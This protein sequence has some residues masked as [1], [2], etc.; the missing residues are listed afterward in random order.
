MPRP[1]HIVVV[2]EENRSYSDVIG[3]PDAPYING[4]AAHGAVFPRSFAVAHPSQPNYLA[5]F[6]GST[7]GV[8]SDSCPQTFTAVSLGQ[9][10]AV[11]GDSLGGY[12]EDLPA[13]GF[14]GCTHGGYARK[15]NPWSDFPAVPAAVNRALGAFPADYATLPTVSFVIPDLDHDM[16]DGSVAEGDAWLRERLNG[17]AQWAGTHNSLLILTWDEDDG[18]AGNQIPTIILGA[19]VQPGRY[20]ERVTHYRV[21]RTIEEA[22][23]LPPL[24]DAAHTAPISDI[25]AR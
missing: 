3:A 8:T 23:E 21:L 19:G 1:D 25:W 12:S 24:G 5:L 18:S 9:Q 10:L 17:Y 14:T 7:Q 6:S 2:V 20:N 4:L 22:L 16:H 13:T 15:H 11:A